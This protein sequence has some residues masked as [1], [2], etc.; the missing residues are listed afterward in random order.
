[1]TSTV[2]EGSIQDDYFLFFSDGAA[3]LR[4]AQGAANLVFGLLHVVLGVP[5]AA[6]DRGDHLRRGLWGSFYS[7]PEVLGVSIRKGRYDLL[8]ERGPD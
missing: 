7:V 1:M 3:W 6:F 4:P 8:P 2:Y 5:T